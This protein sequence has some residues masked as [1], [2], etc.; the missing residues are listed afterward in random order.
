[1]NVR[2]GHANQWGQVKSKKPKPAPKK[3]VVNSNNHS[4][5]RGGKI[6]NKKK[7]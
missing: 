6:N 2:K 1:M 4:H 5:P 3:S 7:I